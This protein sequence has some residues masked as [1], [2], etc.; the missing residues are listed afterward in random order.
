VVELS[1]YSASLLRAPQEVRCVKTHHDETLDL[2][3]RTVW[4]E[5]I[6]V[7]R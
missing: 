2:F 1:R 4:L 5:C 7:R 6:K 3:I